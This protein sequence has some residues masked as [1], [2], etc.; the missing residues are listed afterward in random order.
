MKRRASSLSPGV[1]AMQL[2]AWM[3]LPPSKFRNTPPASSMMILS[4][5]K[6]QAAAEGSIQMSAWPEA[7]IIASGA[8][9]NPRTDQ[10]RAIQSSIRSLNGVP[11]SLPNALKHKVDSSTEDLDET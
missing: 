8:P 3:L 1:H 9:A 6:S 2:P 5:A 10:N 4:G 7:T 11:F